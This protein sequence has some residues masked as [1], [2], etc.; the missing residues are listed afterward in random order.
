M[1]SRKGI[2][3]FPDDVKVEAVRLFLE[4]GLSRAEVAAKVGVKHP[5]QIQR[6]VRCYRREGVAGLRKPKGGRRR[7]TRSEVERLRM[8]VALLKKFHTELREVQLAQRNIG[9]STTCEAHTK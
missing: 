4:E 7:E 2:K 5:K 6:W 8:E 1:G 3:N 9:R